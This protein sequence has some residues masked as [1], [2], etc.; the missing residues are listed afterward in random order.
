[1]LARQTERNFEILFLYS[2]TDE[3]TV[4]L[5][6]SYGAN[7]IKIRSNP[8]EYSHSRAINVGAEEAHGEFVV[9]LSADAVPTSENWL[10]S[11]L[12]PFDD[13]QVAGVYGAHLPGTQANLL[14][15][16]R[17]RLWYGSRSKPQ[18][19]GDN[20]GF[21]NAN[22]ALRRSLWKE[23]HFDESLTS[24][25]DYDWALWA[26]ENGYVVVYSPEASVYHSH[27]K[28]YGIWRY[29]KRA[30]EFKL[31][32]QS[33]DKRHG[34][35]VTA[36]QPYYLAIAIS[37]LGAAAIWW[38]RFQSIVNG[39]RALLLLTGPLALALVAALGIIQWLSER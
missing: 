2:G 23:H 32:R 33:I 39:T 3:S 12:K 21:S 11:M 29:L 10:A 13:E 22:S 35:P 16:Y 6:Q 38:L 31:L 17:T 7:V 15:R 24:V 30:I 28:R 9:C 20:P 8:H 37:L 4:A 14:D 19:A 26:Q 25:E 18:A 5:A 1:M 27:A 34:L 36:P